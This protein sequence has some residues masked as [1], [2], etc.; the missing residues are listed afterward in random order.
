MTSLGDKIRYFRKR[1]GLSQFKLE[2]EISASAG[3]ISRIENG[4]VNPSKETLT[5]IGEVLRLNNYELGSLYGLEEVEITKTD[6]K[7]AI[8]KVYKYFNNKNTFA[9]LVDSKGYLH[10]ASLGF[11]QIIPNSD[12][13]QQLLPIHLLEMLVDP[14]YGINDLFVD[15]DKFLM[16]ELAYFRYSNQNRLQEDWWL[17]LLKDLESANTKFKEYWEKS[18]KIE[19][20]Y[21]DLENRRIKIKVDNKLFTFLTS[22]RYLNSDS[23]FEILDYYLERNY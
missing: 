23:R 18:S 9:L 3:S 16:N 5:K 20:P 13:L 4:E 19:E 17:N 11:I 22:F 12:I 7:N 21:I 6:I 14:V 8:Q 10:Y 15:K 1:S 2:L